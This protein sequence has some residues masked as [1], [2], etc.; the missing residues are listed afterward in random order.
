VRHIRERAVPGDPAAATVSADDDWSLANRRAHFDALC[1]AGAQLMTAASSP[2]RTWS[3][4]IGQHRVR[5]LAR[6]TAAGIRDDRC[7]RSGVPKLA[8]RAPAGG[9]TDACHVVHSDGKSQ[10]QRGG[11]AD[12]GSAVVAISVILMLTVAGCA[13][14]PPS[15]EQTEGVR[16]VRAQVR[17]IT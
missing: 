11:G 13:S 8:R 10:C 4:F 5:A 6:R 2:G 15:P 1:A 14:G 12:V 3:A 7:R 9:T 17:G 16:V